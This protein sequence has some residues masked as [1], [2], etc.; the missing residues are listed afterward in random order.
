MSLRDELVSR[1]RAQLAS[2]VV[3]AVAGGALTVGLARLLDP[4][5]YG[6]L[7]LALAVLGTFRLA[8]RFGLARSAGR[9]IAEYDETDPSQ[10]PHIVRNSL[11][12][13]IGSILIAVLVLAASHQY[14]AS[15]LDEPELAPFLLLGILFVVF[16]TSMAYLERVIQGFEAI[17]FA[18]LLR[19]LERG[20]RSI[21]AL[22]LVVAGFGAIG[23][24][25]GYVLSSLLV[26]IIGFAYLYRRV[27]SH[28]EPADAVKPGLNRR[29]GEYAVP[30][31]ATNTSM[32][33]DNMIDTFLVGFFLSP[34]SVSY[35]VISKQVVRF[36]ELPVNALSFT[37]SPTFGSQKAAGNVD[38]LSRLYEKSLTNALLLYIPAG[39]GLILIAEPMIQLVFGPD[40]SGAVVVVQVLA[41]YVILMAVT[42]ISDNGLDYLGRARERAIARGLTAGLNVGLNVI[43][44]PLV[45]VVGAAIATVVTYG[46]YTAANVYI[47]AQEFNLR[48][49]F[50]L[51]R[52]GLVAV[53]TATMSIV[54]LALTGYISGWIT[55]SLVV[56]A[57]GVVWGVLSVA[58]GLLDVEKVVS[59]VT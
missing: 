21:L 54:V 13:N 42:K 9:Y 15:V 37:I 39:F 38:R 10:I 43:L 36:L 1:F 17:T 14:I 6:L 33:L 46:L 55:F 26:S 58:T 20:S 47:A 12:L 56:V 53:I 48:V 24:L 57:G 50:I 51:R 11:L 45:G 16:G 32:V 29:I 25:W 49:E 34:V 22:G 4:T 3:T 59:I 19:G 5:S 40:Y 2:K 41:L 31:M 8:A 52:L 44:I 27:R 23:A 30:I 35:Y 18:A 7:F 28:Y